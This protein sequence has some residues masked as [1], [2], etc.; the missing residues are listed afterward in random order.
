M[1]YD[2]AH[3]FG[4][5]IH[6]RGIGSFGDLSMFSFHPTKLFHTG[7]GGAL[8]Y[9]SNRLQEE[10]NLLRNFGIKN[11]DEVCLAGL[12]GKMSEIQAAM[13]LSVYD[14]LNKEYAR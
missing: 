4:C 14:D 6:G 3:A 5:E 10:I 9:S 2:A 13:G 1:I 7:E 11:E 8:T 12:N